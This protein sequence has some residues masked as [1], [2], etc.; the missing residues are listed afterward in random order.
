MRNFKN[1][2]FYIFVTGGF[3]LLIYWILNQGKLLES[4]RNIVSDNFR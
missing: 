4:G 3:S 2:I 1:S